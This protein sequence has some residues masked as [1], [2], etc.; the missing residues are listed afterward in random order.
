MLTIHTVLAA[1]ALAAPAGFE[2]TKEGVSG[3]TLML[4]QPDAGVVPMRAECRWPDVTAEEFDAL[5]SKWEDHEAYFSTISE[6]DVLSRPAGKV[7]F[8][9]VH[10]TRGISDRE[11]VLLGERTALDGG[12]FRYAWTLSPHQLTVSGGRVAPERDDGFWEVRP[13]PEGGVDVVHQ[14]T[15]DPGGRVP[16][17][18]V[19]WFQTSGLATVVTDLHEY[20][21]TH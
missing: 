9:Q 13:N 19:R 7:E 2:V 6:S 11:V 18:V 20:L 3:C 14:L 4:G 10:T 21:T 17:F 16:G 12:G 15:Y 5:F 8:R 1:I